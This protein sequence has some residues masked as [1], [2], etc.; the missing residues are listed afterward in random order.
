MLSEI[1]SAA[2]TLAPS[3]TP[4]KIYMLLHCDGWNVFPPSVTG[5]KGLPVAT[6]A[7]PSVHVYA[8]SGVISVAEVGFDSGITIGCAWA[9]AMTRIAPTPTCDSHVTLTES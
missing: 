7:R 8:S 6:I 4:G 3:P 5:S 1:V 2:Q 9:L